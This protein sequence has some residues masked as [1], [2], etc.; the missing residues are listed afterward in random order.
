M[1]PS[2]DFRIEL[3]LLIPAIW[4]LLQLISATS[5]NYQAGDAEIREQWDL[6]NIKILP[7]KD[8]QKEVLLSLF[9]LRNIPINQADAEVLATVPGIGPVLA[10]AIIEERN[11]DGFYRQAEDLVRVHGIGARRAE[12]FQ[13]YLRFD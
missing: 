1:N 2:G 3:L 11:R 13:S 6:S 4:L 5:S 8:S 12:Q 9:E 7:D 10:R